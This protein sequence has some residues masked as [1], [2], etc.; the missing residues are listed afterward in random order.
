ML[1]TV[2]DDLRLLTELELTATQLL[3]IKMLVPDPTYSGSDW[4]KLSYKMSIEFQNTTKG[5]TPEELADLIS[6]DIIIDLNDHGKAFYDYFELS[7]K[8]LR[9]FSLK[10]YPMPVQLLDAYPTRFKGSDGRYFLGITASAEEIAKD[11]LRFINNDIEE[12]KKILDDVAWG[13]KNNAI[14]LGLKK[15]VLTKYWLVIREAR[16]K[17]QNTAADVK[18]I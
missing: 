11:Y 5:L 10:V 6:R 3:F 4:K 18:I 13:I 2:E 15:F 7:P 9:H 14:Q 8:F 16:L 17:K 12:H 1:F